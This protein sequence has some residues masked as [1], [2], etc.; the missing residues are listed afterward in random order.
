MWA[1]AIASLVMLITPNVA[2]ADTGVDVS[3]WQGC[4]NGLT[5]KQSGVNFA[6]VKTSEGTGFVDRFADCSVQSAKRAGIRVGVYHFARPEKNTPE[7]EARYF[8]D[9]TRGYRGQGIIPVLDWESPAK[10]N[11]AWAKRWLDLVSAEWGTKPLIYMSAST[12]H[13]ADWNA[14]ANADYGLWVAGYPRSGPDGLR[15]PGSI[16][17]SIDPWKIA[18]VWQ[19]TSSAS[20][21]G[22]G[23]AVDADWFYGDA[24]TWAAYAG[25]SSPSS[26]APAPQPAR[27]TPFCVVVRPGDSLSAI[28]ARTGRQPWSAWSGYRSGDPNRIYA[29]EQVCYGGSAP[30]TGGRHVVQPGDTLWAIARANGVPM[31]A[32]HGYRSGNPSRI[33]A[34]EV[35]Y[36]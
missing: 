9:N 15:N 25:S 6:F 17:Y 33:Y 10:W 16:P 19:Y 21:P 22:V 30:S 1:A 26:P 29:G 18:A 23:G 28:A 8:L 3:N 35:L 36:W 20:V 7:A 11:S 13:E 24:S 14:V 31:S 12:I 34:G 2:F 5:A 32:I 27:P 4:L